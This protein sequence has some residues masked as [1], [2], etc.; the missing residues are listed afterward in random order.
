MRKPLS[1]ALAAIVAVA[2]AP[3]APA[4]PNGA[5]RS[6]LPDAS[7]PDGSALVLSDRS[8]GFDAAAHLTAV[9]APYIE[10]V[11]WLLC[12][13]G[14]D[15]GDGLIDQ[16]ELAQCD[17]EIGSDNTPNV[18]SSGDP[19][20]PENDRAYD[21]VFGSPAGLNLRVG[22]VLVLG[23]AGSGRVVS[24]SSQ[25]CIQE[26]VENVVLD[27]AAGASTGETSAGEIV[28]VCT[29]DTSAAQGGPGSGTNDLCEVGGA[30]A[31]TR[32][33]V[34]ARFKPF[35]HGDAVPNDGFVVRAT[36]DAEVT[37]LNL[38]M[39]E[40]GAG[41][42]PEA[43]PGSDEGPGAATDAVAC[44]AID[45]F[46]TT[47][48]WECVVPSTTLEDNSKLALWIW[49]SGAVSSGVT[50]P[51]RYDAHYAASVERQP[52]GPGNSVLPDHIHLVY[53]G[54]G[55]PSDPCHTGD[56]FRESIG[57]DR[58]E[59][60]A[61]TF[62]EQAGTDI[63]ATTAVP[64]GGRLEWV[65]A[66]VIGE[67]SF[68]GTP[69]GETGP[70]GRAV[71]TVGLNPDATR[72]AA[73]IEVRLLDDEGTV[74]GSAAVEL[75]GHVDP[76]PSHSRVLLRY[77]PAKSVFTGRVNSELAFCERKRMVVV[78]RARPGRDAVVARDRT[79]RD[80]RFEAAHSG[81]PGRYY[82]VAKRTGT[83]FRLCLRARS[84]TIRVRR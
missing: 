61:C 30:G 34:D 84:I 15:G 36:T 66:S 52:G 7:S 21:I 32:S 74:V 17:V 27:V 55:D 57:G 67:V 63:P 8:D 14:A 3:A 71:A 51:V 5:I 41:T 29:A 45:R 38:S 40:S 81:R 35:E 47:T 11:Q 54:T 6:F 42:E 13:P 72:H 19:F 22:D 25:N 9:A 69:P 82:A 18:I 20:S 16:D 79:G 53:E 48:R 39:D 78:K 12:H 50:N 1:A 24:G 4:A 77:R 46:V 33:D 83:G 64:G 80:G 65:M 49:G 2:V 28:Q 23:C 70:G 43:G 10:R 62:G 37:V 56:S 76:P 73:D 58:V 31:G 75:R 26:L 68:I 59:L 44:V 60:L